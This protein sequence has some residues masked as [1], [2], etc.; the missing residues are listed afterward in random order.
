VLKDLPKAQNPALLVGFDQSDDACVYDL[1]DGRVLIQTADFFPPMV[2]DPYLFGQVAAAN[3]LSD[4]YAMGGTPTLALNL[5]CFPSCLPLEAVRDILA[6]GQSKVTEAGAVIA[7]G[8]SIEDDVPK[9]GLCVTGFGEKTRIWANRGARLGDLLVLTKQIGSGILATAAKAEVITA[10]Q[11]RPAVDIMATLNGPAAKLAAAFDVSTCTDITGF[12]LI[13]HALEL[14]RGSGVT[15]ALQ[16]K[17]VP[18]MAHAAEMAAMGIVPGGAARN[19][20]F[21]APFMAASAIDAA[22]LDILADPQT[23]GGLLIALPERDA[24]ALSHQLTESGITGAIVGRV[25]TF[26][27][28]ALR[29]E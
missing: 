25:E 26:G 13:G 23:S 15:I 27:Q 7:G 10:A 21:A 3:A 1:G 12:G 19:L 2:D 4:V 11:F 16:S 9:Y 8:H 17:A 22:A 6:G 28:Y 20:D 29:V 14:A 18:I 24:V 5:L